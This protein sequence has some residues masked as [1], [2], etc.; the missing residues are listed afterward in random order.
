MEADPGA[1]VRSVRD[2]FL[3]GLCPI[4]IVVPYHFGVV[5]DVCPVWVQFSPLE[6]MLVGRRSR[7][8]ATDGKISCLESGQS[9]LDRTKPVG[10]CP[11]V[12]LWD[13]LLYVFGAVVAG[14]S[15]LVCN[16]WSLLPFVFYL[17]FNL[18]FD[19]FDKYIC[20][21]PIIEVC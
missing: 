16:Y 1:Q 20:R 8:C 14:I 21:A 2:L 5:V 6:G 10:L 11:G 13:V 7:A 12:L 17:I 19:A 18:A 15:R 4:G 3:F 9:S